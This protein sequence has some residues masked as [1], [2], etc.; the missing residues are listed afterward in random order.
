[1]ICYACGQVGHGIHTCFALMGMILKGNLLWDQNGRITFRDR[2]VV[3]QEPD[4]IIIEAA[5]KHKTMQ[6]HLFTMSQ[7]EASEY[8]Q[9]DAEPGNVYKTDVLAAEHHPRRI[10]ENCKEIFD[11]VAVSTSKGKENVNPNPL[12]NGFKKTPTLKTRV[13][14]RPRMGTKANSFY[15]RETIPIASGSSKKMEE[16]VSVLIDVWQPRMVDK[17]MSD[18]VMKELQPQKQE[19]KSRMPLRQS[20]VSLQ[21]GETQIVTTILNT[22]IT[23]S[24]SEV[25]AS[26]QEVSDQLTDLL[27]RENPKP[28]VVHY[29]VVSSKNAGSLIQIPLWPENQKIFGIIDTGSELNVINRRALQG[30]TKT[31]IDPQRKVVM[32][33]ANRGAGS[34]QGHVSDVLLKCRNVKTFANLYVKDELPFDLLLGRPWQWENLVTIDK[35]MDKTYLVFKDADNIEVT[36]ELLVEDHTPRPDY[37]F[38]RHK[39]P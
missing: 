7:N 20:Q 24:I 31:P 35:W 11:G 12:S 19:V 8:Y 32:N 27:K 13:T 15:N 26:S 10:K 39:A 23:I 17:Q 34:L 33:D 2:S 25:L 1:M 6:S 30:L 28:A 14:G 3:Q 4:E 37:P 29:A 18:V 16:F 22:L 36:Y 9:S 38:D 21:V 5:S